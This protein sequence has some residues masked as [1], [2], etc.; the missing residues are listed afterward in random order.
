MLIIILYL[1][2][3]EGRDMSKAIGIKINVGPG[4]CTQEEVDDFLQ[5]ATCELDVEIGLDQDANPLTAKHYDYI[6]GNIYFHFNS[7]IPK[8]L[9]ERFFEE[10][11]ILPE[12]EKE[13]ER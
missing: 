12:L 3:L 11:E 5:E 1:E 7:S 13:E 6:T 9:L 10:D 2:T 4:L 8:V